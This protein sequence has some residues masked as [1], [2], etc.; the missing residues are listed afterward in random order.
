MTE[1]GIPFNGD[2][3]RAIL[4]GAKTQTRRPIKPQPDAVNERGEPVYQVVDDGGTPTDCWYPAKPKMQPGDIM[5]PTA[6]GRKML[7][8]KVL[9]VRAERVQDI[10]EEDARAEG[11]KAQS[12]ALSPGIES[13]V[14]TFAE[15]WDDIY[16]DEYKHGPYCWD[17]N[18]WVWVY[19]FAKENV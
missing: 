5:C 3:I 6:G 13:Y 2:M 17:N 15:L 4:S 9:G 19:E 18:P 14:A 8:R 11:V 10:S 12:V 7:R 16:N 1:H